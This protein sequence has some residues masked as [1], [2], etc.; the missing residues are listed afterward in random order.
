LKVVKKAK[1]V[2]ME[3]VKSNKAQRLNKDAKVEN[4]QHKT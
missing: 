4:S 2:A 1:K 3:A